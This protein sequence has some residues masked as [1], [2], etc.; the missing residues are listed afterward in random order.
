M[1]I[2]RP[3]PPDLA[4]ANAQAAERLRQKLRRGSAWFYWIAALSLVNT[5][6]FIFGAN[7]N[8]LIGLGTTQLIT[9]IV[10]G[11][12]DGIG[13]SAAMGIAKLIAVILSLAMTAIVAL[14]GYLSRKGNRPFLIG[15]MVLYAL[16]GLL[17]LLFREWFGFLLHLFVLWGLYGALQ[18]AGELEALSA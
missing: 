10:L 16:D 13:G 3:Q 18:A 5:L 11:I 6:L 14:F 8:F 4:D 15:G 2:E 9:A 1:D 7:I 17:L 12:G